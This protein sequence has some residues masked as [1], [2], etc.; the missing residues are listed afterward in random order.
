M[1][2]IPRSYGAHVSDEGYRTVPLSFE[3]GQQNTA[4]LYFNRRVRITRLRGEVTKALAGTDAGTI[5][6]KNDAAQAMASGT[7][8]FAASSALNTRQSAVPTTN[9]L[10][11]A[12]SFMEL[13]AA[14]TTAGGAVTVYVEYELAP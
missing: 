5:T 1:A 12:G 7:L 11:A 3:S 2:T 14:K 13:T 9:N 6:P 4:R 10:V 8:T